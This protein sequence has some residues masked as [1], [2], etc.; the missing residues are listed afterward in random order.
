MT[1]SHTSL[2]ANKNGFNIYF[3]KQIK[4]NINMANW[5]EIN[6]NGLHS[7]ERLDKLED[8]TESQSRH[9]KWFGLH[10]TCQE[11]C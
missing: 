9:I 1:I 4:D 7:L 11:Y 2:C 10:V 6:R 5:S 3:F 8:I